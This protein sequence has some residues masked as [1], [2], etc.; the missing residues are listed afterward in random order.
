MNITFKHLL[1][2]IVA[3]VLFANFAMAQKQTITLQQA[4]DMASQHSPALKISKLKND[5]NQLH[6]NELYNSLIPSVSLMDNYTRISNNIQ[7]LPPIN[8]FGRSFVL[9]PQIL[10]QFYNRASVQEPIFT[11][12]RTYN[13]ASMFNAQIESGQK[14]NAINAMETPNRLVSVNA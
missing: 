3:L 8:F 6:K 14:S 5:V 7:E 2:S 10:D 13:Y 12:F 11:G 9:N 1:F 4:M